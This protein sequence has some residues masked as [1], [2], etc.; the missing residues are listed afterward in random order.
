[1]RVVVAGCP[2][3]VENGER[4][5][6]VERHALQR[7][8]GDGN[9]GRELTVRI[10]DDRIVARD[11]APRDGQPAAISADRGLVCVRHQRF[12]GTID[13]VTFEATLTRE[14]SDDAFAIE[15]LLRTALSCRLPLEDGLLLHSAGVV[16]DGRAN[17]FFG[18]SGAGK[19]T[20]AELLGGTILSD[21]LVAVCGAHV[22]AT[23][24]WGSLDRDDAPHGAHPL[25]ALLDL[26]R[27]DDV[28]L[29]PLA[30]RE[31]RRRLLLATVVPPDPYLWTHAL[32]VIERLSRGSVLR[33]AWAPTEPNARRVAAL[34]ATLV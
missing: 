18:V 27:G 30:P 8:G 3:R 28:Q 5:T 4:L 19:S 10:N 6:V 22:R 7:L 17:L 29:E 24:F 12:S 23:G 33:L 20:I 21:E 13:P 31:A 32:R 11:D 34:L 9:G 26:A 14:I 2:F 25:G 1:M 15:I 16:L